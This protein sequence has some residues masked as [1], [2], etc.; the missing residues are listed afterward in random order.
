MVVAC[1]A[2]V[3]RQPQASLRLDA[4]FFDQRGVARQLAAEGFLG[5]LGAADADGVALLGHGFLHSGIAESDG[6][7]IVDFLDLRRRHALG[8]HH[9]K[10]GFHVVN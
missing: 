9:G 3:K 10:P 5:L 6:H 7:R 2:C 1:A 4:G 8:A